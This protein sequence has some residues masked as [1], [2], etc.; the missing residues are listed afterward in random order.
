MLSRYPQGTLR[1]SVGKDVPGRNR[2]F[3]KALPGIDLTHRNVEPGCNVLH[4]LVTL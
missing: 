2:G 3:V 4:G 1:A